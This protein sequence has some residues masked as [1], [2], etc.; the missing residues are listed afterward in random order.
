MNGFRIH[1]ISII[2][3]IVFVIIFLIVFDIITY[4]TRPVNIDTQN[5]AGLYGEEKNSLDMVYIGGSAAFVYWEA[6]S[7]FKDTGM[8]SYVYSANTMQC[9]F[10]KTMIKEILKNQKPEVILIDARAFQYRDKEQPPREVPYRNVLTTM[11]FSINR[12]N[13]IENNVPTYLN[14]KKFSY[15][16]DIVKYHTILADALAKGEMYSLGDNFN[17]MKNSYDNHYKGFYFV[18]KVDQINKY[19][20]YTDEEMKPDEE[21]DKILD[22][23]LDYLDTID[24]NIL[25][26]VSPYSERI[27]HKKLFN[28]I[29]K[30][31]SDRGHKLL[32]VNDY[33]NEIGLDFKIDFYNKDHVNIFG[34]DKYTKF[35]EDYLIKNY[36]F[37]DHR[38]DNKYYSWH[39]DYEE[40]FKEAFDTR[41]KIKELINE[42][43]GNLYIKQ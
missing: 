42:K 17:M 22:D 36:K 35:L 39:L 1:V 18:P 32:D 10:Y 7:A 33:R 24:T 31:V 38:N 28:Y 43:Y 27:E 37:S 13:F 6:L 11:P 29:E 2:K 5:I 30:R 41:N 34:A 19:V 3:I 15:H 8:A 4:C 9:E 40:W 12:A 16:F 23:L 20:Y 21:T 25:F 14:E 26:I